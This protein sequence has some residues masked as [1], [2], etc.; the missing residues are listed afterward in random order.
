[1]T[2]PYICSSC[3]HAADCPKGTPL[4]VCSCDPNEARPVPYA[5]VLDELPCY[6]EADEWDDWLGRR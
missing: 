6:S 2:K 4:L 1:M 5:E 3:G